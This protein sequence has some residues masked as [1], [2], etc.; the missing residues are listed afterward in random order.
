MRNVRTHRRALDAV[1]LSHDLHR[2]LATGRGKSARRHFHLTLACVLVFVAACGSGN[3]AQGSSVPS[4]AEQGSQSE[5]QKAALADGRVTFDEYEAGFLRYKDCLA[6]TG[7]PL[8][9]VQFD[10]ATQLYRADV[11]G[12]AVDG[13]ADDQCYRREFEALDKSWQANT[14][15]PGNFDVKVLG[16]YR[17][18]LAKAGVSLPDDKPGVNYLDLMHQNGLDPLACIKDHGGGGGGG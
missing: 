8:T 4:V 17:D 14:D 2:V 12:A 16:W 10:S 5:A 11:A 1:A 18:C 9:N 13:G 6:S 7:Y 15:R 3:P